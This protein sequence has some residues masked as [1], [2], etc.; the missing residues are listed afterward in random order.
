MLK[1]ISTM[2]LIDKLNALIPS[3]FRSAI[4]HFSVWVTLFTILYSY[5][6]MMGRDFNA[7]FL[8]PNAIYVLLFYLNYSVLV[9]KL[10]FRGRVWGYVLAI[11]VIFTALFFLMDTL[12]EIADKYITDTPQR[13]ERHNILG[14]VLFSILVLAPSLSIKMTI[15][16]F[17]AQK[18]IQESERMRTEMELTSL[19]NQL[20]PHFL[21]NSLN[22]IYALIAF[23]PK[24]AQSSL[25]NV[26][27]LL[28]YQLY[29]SDY[30]EV[31]LEK[32]VQFIEN[33]SNL[34]RLRLT[35]SVC[36]EVDL[37]TNC[38]GTKVAPL[39]FISLVENAFKHGVDSE[40]ESHINIRMTVVGSVIR[41]VCRNSYHPKTAQDLSGSGIGLVNL[42]RRLELIYPHSHTYDVKQIDNEY[43]TT[44]IINT[45]R[46]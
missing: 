42:V 18:R 34:M 14:H 36:V 15:K 11:V 39:L 32:E 13:P 21:F 45:K 31:E 16:W 38:E 27:D 30:A 19:K 23:N 26:C 41:F 28:R 24:V 8:I 29:D 17:D 43:I 6:A 35:D 2:T 20:N 44:L 22:N 46:K 1:I 37:P 5:G 9:E 33:Y 25:M 10:L 40:K 12:S 7:F 3:R 4:I